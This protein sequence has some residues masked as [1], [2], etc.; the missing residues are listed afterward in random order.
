VLLPEIPFQV[1]AGCAMAAMGAAV[2]MI[3]MSMALIGTFLVEGGL[4][5]SAAILVAVVTA[6]AIRFALGPPGG[7]SD[8]EEASAAAASG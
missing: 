8:A 5:E 4:L 6:Y 2:A 7:T 1:A 3:P